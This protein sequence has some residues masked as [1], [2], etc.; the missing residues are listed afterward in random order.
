MIQPSGANV[1]SPSPSKLGLADQDLPAAD[2]IVVL[3]G[4]PTRLKQ[5]ERYRQQ[6]PRATSSP[7][8]SRPWQIG[9][10]AARLLLPSA[11][12][13]PPIQ[14]TPPAPPCSPAL[15]WPVVASRSSQTHR[16]LPAPASTAS[17][18]VTPCASPSGG[19]PAA[20]AP[21]LCPRSLPA[22]GPIVGLR[23]G[24]RPC[25]SRSGVVPAAGREGS[26][27]W[28]VLGCRR[29]RFLSRQDSLAAARA[30]SLPR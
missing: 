16:L 18:S 2:L 6:L 7:P 29:P 3:D 30:P 11:S 9:S 26:A 22:N 25:E 4:T 19:S 21:G 24:G 1:P 10:S 15:P 23:G 8:R 13:S 14:I 5:A 27:V 17:S 20:P 28:S 12:G